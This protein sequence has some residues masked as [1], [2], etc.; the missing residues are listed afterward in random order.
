MLSEYIPVERYVYAMYLPSRHLPVKVRAFID[1]LIARIGTE[2][3]WDHD[4]M[5]VAMLT[6]T[7]TR[8]VAQ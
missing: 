8:T 5:T 6:G 4:N 3:Y 7:I 2:P 1:F